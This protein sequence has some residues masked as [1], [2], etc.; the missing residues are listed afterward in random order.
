MDI[1]VRSRSFEFDEKSSV[2]VRGYDLTIT[3][4]GFDEK[5][6]EE[7]ECFVDVPVTLPPRI[8]QRINETDL[9]PVSRLYVDANGQQR[10]K[11]YYD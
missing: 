9:N 5:S 10:F 4:P 7:M 3:E 6:S 2:E 8:E 1:K 11:A